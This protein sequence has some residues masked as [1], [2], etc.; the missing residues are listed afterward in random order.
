MGAFAL[1]DGVVYHTNSAYARGVDALSGACTSGST[2]HREGET[3]RKPR[4]STGSVGTTSTTASDACGGPCPRRRPA[5]SGP[6][7]VL[8][9]F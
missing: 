8:E 6:V 4:A 3:R 1:E 2:G 7:E 5:P 9:G